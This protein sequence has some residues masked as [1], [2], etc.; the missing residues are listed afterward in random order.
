[1]LERVHEISCF[2]GRCG[3]GLL[4]IFD[5]LE[6]IGIHL[7]DCFPFFGTRLNLPLFIGLESILGIEPLVNIEV[8]WAT[9][10]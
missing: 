3:L 7:H 10:S 6:Y 9:T 8:K 1:M 4:A 2:C 5:G